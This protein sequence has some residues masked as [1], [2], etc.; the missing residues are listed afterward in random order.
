MKRLP[1]LLAAATLAASAA[2]AIA[3]PPPAEERPGRFTM[4]PTDGGFLR[5]DTA[6]GDVTFCAKA[7]A[8]IECKPVKDDRDL[9]IEINRLSNENKA[10]KA[11][12]KQLEDIVGL[13]NKE[14]QAPRKL[15]LPSEEDVD[16]AL[17]Y[18]E[19]M[20]KKF[21]DKLKDLEGSGKS[22]PL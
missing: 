16:K 11:D 18:M 5:L 13:G 12:I 7:G 19:R 4:Q 22:T 1:L 21:R 2:T 8:T 17:G 15:E 20:F 14:S 9:Q 3:A 6:T 10:L